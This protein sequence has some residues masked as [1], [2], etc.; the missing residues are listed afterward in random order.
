MSIATPHTSLNAASPAQPQTTDSL[1]SKP[2][3]TAGL[4]DFDSDEPLA[5]CPM[6]NNGDTICESCQ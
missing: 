1:A 5:V 6:R 3:D 2:I 4:L